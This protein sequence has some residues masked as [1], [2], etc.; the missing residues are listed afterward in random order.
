MEW[1]LFSGLSE[2]TKT[3]RFLEVESSATGS[4]GNEKVNKL[5]KKKKIGD[6]WIISQALL[7][8]ENRPC[9][10]GVVIM[11][12]RLRCWPLRAS[13]AFLS[14]RAKPNLTQNPHFPN[15]DP[16][17]PSLPSPLIII[18][19]TNNPNNSNTPTPP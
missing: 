14:H 3:S 7:T 16:M 9:I 10:T 15:A 2:Q 13:S 8:N 11:S 6:D 18:P 5:E 4:R 19:R 17:H 1:E 12:P